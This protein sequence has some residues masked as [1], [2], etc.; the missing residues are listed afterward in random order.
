MG[1]APEGT[2]E[3]PAPERVRELSK[4]WGEWYLEYV[5][6]NAD[7]VPDPTVLHEEAKHFANTMARCEPPI[8]KETGN[9]ETQIN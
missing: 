2:G 5:A 3:A 4:L 6:F 7:D 1:E 9:G 8:A